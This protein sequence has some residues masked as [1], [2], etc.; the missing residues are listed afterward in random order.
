MTG[1]DLVFS[2]VVASHGRAGLLARLLASLDRG[3]TAASTSVEVIVVDST[4]A[5][6]GTAI[7]AACT[8]VGAKLIEGPLSV[9]CKRNLGARSAQGRWLLFVDSD[10][11]VSP[12]IFVAYSQAVSADPEM[13]AAAGPTVFRGEDTAFTRLI[14]GSSLLSPFRQPATVS[15][16]LLWAT[17]SNL[18][19]HTD[20]F[21]A[22][23]GFRED[24][25]FRLG[26]DDTDFCLRLRAHGHRIA[27]IP[28]AVCFHTWAT[29]GRPLAVIRRSF[30]WGWMHAILL[31]AHPKFRRLDAPGL[32]AHALGTLAL[33]ALAVLIFKR[34]R[35]FVAT[36]CFFLLAILLHATQVAFG[37][38]NLVR[39]A[40]AD[41]ALALVELPFG[42]GRALGSISRG[43]LVGVFCR[44]DGDDA[45]MDDMLPE[46]VRSLWSDHLA[47]MLTLLLVIRLL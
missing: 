31:K 43:S 19:V 44:L 10:C 15:G 47:F 26:G 30:R 8:S 33:S 16:S 38:P 12:D 35:L 32:P 36:P 28:S 41:L 42:F 1:P 13:R 37:A 9:R 4:P 46:M 18:L 5:E 29:W 6:E 27:A 24:F 45:A 22:V 3:R 40:V 20:A 21:A 34:P 25:P 7:K 11:E 23:G 2:V 39:A 17:T 14:A